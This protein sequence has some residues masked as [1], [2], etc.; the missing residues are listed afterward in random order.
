MQFVNVIMGP[1]FSGKTTFLNKLLL[2]DSKT[3][4]IIAHTTRPMR[5][6]EVDG[7]DYYFERDFDKDEDNICRRDYRVANGDVWSYWVNKN[8][9]VQ[10]RTNLLILDYKGFDELFNLFKNDDNTEVLGI[11]LATPMKIIQDRINHSKRS[12]EDRKETFR[13]LKS[14]LIEFENIEKDNRVILM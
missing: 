4:S 14:D 2:G 11:Y 9:I 8:D 5:D 7:V 12:H 6:G 1:T 3:H 13:R 10:N